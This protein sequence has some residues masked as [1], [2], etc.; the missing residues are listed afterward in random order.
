[1]ISYYKFFLCINLIF[2]NYTLKKHFYTLL[3]QTGSGIFISFITIVLQKGT[4]VAYISNKT[5][6][7]ISTK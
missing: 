2:N 6:I 4:L 7:Y 5:I 1:M 3:S